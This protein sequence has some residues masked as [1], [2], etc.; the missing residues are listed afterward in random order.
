LLIG[1]LIGFTVVAARRGGVLRGG[2]AVVGAIVG[3]TLFAWLLITLVSALRPG[4]FWRA[5]PIWT[6]LTVYAVTISAAA[7]CLIGISGTLDRTQLRPA[8]WFIF[9]LLGGIIGLIAPGGIIFFIFPPLIA[10]AGMLARRWWPS[11]ER[12]GSYAAIL[13]LYLTWGAMLGLLQELL[14][15]GPMWVFAPLAALLIVPFLIEARP[16]LAGSRLRASA[17][18]SAILTVFSAGLAIA[19]PAY[20]ADRQ[21]RFVIQRVTDAASHKSWWSVVNDGVTLPQ[22]F[23][24]SWKR[25]KLPFSDRER[26]VATAPADPTARAPEVR[27]VTQVRNGYERTLTVRLAANGNS[28]IE[29]IAPEDARIRSAGVGGFIRPVDQGE[30]GKYDLACTGRSCDGATLLITTG[31]LKAINLLVIGAGP[32]PP[33]AAPLLSARPKFARPQYNADARVTFGHVG[34]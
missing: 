15:S 7:V 26:W 4:M 21:Q 34:L 32:L 1:L 13:F 28:D 17:L 9:V 27:L 3:S 11:A 19:A 25:A 29:L 8:F 23:P 24:G 14:N 31:Q 22:S 20:S 30:G 2:V 6:H 5:Y 12:I 33:S 16:L 18:V 10:I